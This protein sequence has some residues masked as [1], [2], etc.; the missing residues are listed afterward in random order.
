[1]VRR[2]AASLYVGWFATALPIFVLC[3]VWFRSSPGVAGL[4]LWWL[5]PVY[6][7]IPLWLLIVAIG[8]TGWSYNAAQASAVDTQ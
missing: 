3:A 4:L 6:E 2:R 5:K 1:M 8:A 7:R